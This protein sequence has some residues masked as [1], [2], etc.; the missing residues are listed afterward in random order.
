MELEATATGDAAEEK[1]KYV[2]PIRC[3]TDIMVTK[4][5]WTTEVTK[6]SGETESFAE[7]KTFDIPEMTISAW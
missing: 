6:E 7:T 2:K 3:N 1:Q 4:M 5:E